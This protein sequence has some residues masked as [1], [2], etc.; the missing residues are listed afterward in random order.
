MNKAFLVVALTLVLLVPSAI[1]GSQRTQASVLCV[2]LTGDA[3]TRRDVKLRNGSRCAAGERKIVLPR[4][5]RGPAG[6]TGPRGPAGTQ[7]ARGPAGPQGSAGPAGAAGPAGQVGPPGPPGPAGPTA[8]SFGPVHLVDLDDTGCGGT[9]VWANST[10]DRVYTV[11]ALEDGTGYLVTRYD[12]DGTFTTVIGAM[13]PGECT[14][15]TFDSND[16]GTFNSVWTREV[17]ITGLADYNPDATMPADG[18][19]ASFLDVFFNVTV[20]PP[21]VSYEFDYTNACG[22]HWRDAFYNGAFV[23]SGSIG[24]CP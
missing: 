9:E 22:D 15:A 5:L 18:S 11:D 20:D 7:G 1:A 14:G 19:W 8:N 13:H 16:V 12:L 3:E 4:G 17:T 10:M 24:D 2:E 6:A 23:A 21:T